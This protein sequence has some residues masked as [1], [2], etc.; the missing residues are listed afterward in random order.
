MMDYG[1]LQ[2]LDSRLRGK[3]FYDLHN[4]SLTFTYVGIDSDGFIMLREIN[5]TQQRFVAPEALTKYF[6]EVPKE[7]GN[8]DFD[9]S[10]GKLFRKSIEPVVDE[11]IKMMATSLENELKKFQ[12]ECGGEKHGWGHSSWCPKA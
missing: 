12:C 4:D 5:N 2:R 3:L 1:T 6:A 7:K 9:L 8:K 11:A 10:V